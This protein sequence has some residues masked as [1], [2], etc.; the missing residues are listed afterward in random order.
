MDD[1]SYNCFCKTEG[2]NKNKEDAGK[3]IYPKFLNILFPFLKEI[4]NFV[5]CSVRT[6]KLILALQ[7]LFGAK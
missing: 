6:K 4:K 3:V 7:V 5:D 2:C 1:G